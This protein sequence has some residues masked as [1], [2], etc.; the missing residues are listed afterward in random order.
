[1]S[2]DSKTG[3]KGKLALKIIIP[4][5][6]VILVAYVAGVVYAKGHFM[7]GTSINNTDVSY[8]TANKA[9]LIFLIK[10]KMRFHQI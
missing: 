7:Y 10:L 8:M 3:N 9:L 2:G 5:V 1:M 4:V 6:A